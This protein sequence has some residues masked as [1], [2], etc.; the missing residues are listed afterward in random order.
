LQ[1]NP[2]I[3]SAI[4][5]F[6]TLLAQHVST[7]QPW[8]I[9]VTVSTVNWVLFRYSSHMYNCATFT[10]KYREEELIYDCGLWQGWQICLGPIT[11][12]REKYTKWPK[13]TPDD[14]K[15]HQMTQNY[16]KW[17]QTTPNGNKLYQMA[18]N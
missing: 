4:R 16:T 10:F 12:K 15:L 17:P 6:H 8:T 7:L 9:T 5:F 14:Q 3:S 11:P 18:I 13:T 1:T 2:P